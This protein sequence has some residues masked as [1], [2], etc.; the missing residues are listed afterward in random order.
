MINT[1]PIHAGRSNATQLV[2]YRIEECIGRVVA[3]GEKRI[4]RVHI[5][6]TSESL[7]PIVAGLVAPMI[8]NFSVNSGFCSD[9]NVQLKLEFGQEQQRNS[10]L[11]F[12]VQTGIVG[13][14]APSRSGWD[15]RGL[16]LGLALTELPCC[17]V[18]WEG[19][20]RLLNSVRI[21]HSSSPRRSGCRSHRRHGTTCPSH[22]SKPERHS[23]WKR[24]LL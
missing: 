10:P 5:K 14:S 15:S 6:C 3:W 21:N 13:R 4:G 23:V 18:C 12:W 11:L 16:K 7:G 9:A 22:L 2:V 8:A 24:K 1:L 20:E 17:Q 19:P